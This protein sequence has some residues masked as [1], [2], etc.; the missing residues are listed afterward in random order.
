MKNKKT[1]SKLRLLRE[2]R[3]LT[4]LEAAQGSKVPLRSLAGYELGEH[5][6]RIAALRKLAAFY[7]VTMEALS[8]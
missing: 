3:R 7:G 8:E 5:A 2:A 6:P 1:I 4:I